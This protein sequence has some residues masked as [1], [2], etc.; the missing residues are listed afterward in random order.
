MLALPAWGGGDEP[1]GGALQIVTVNTAHG[2]AMD[3]MDG[4]QLR[5]GRL[6]GFM[7]DWRLVG[8]HRVCAAVGGSRRF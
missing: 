3:S 7:C 2:C 8:M 6:Y 1:G 4:G 5:R